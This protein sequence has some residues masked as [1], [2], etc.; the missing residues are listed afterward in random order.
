[1]PDR[2]TLPKQRI[3]IRQSKRDKRWRIEV[4]EMDGL[5]EF[6][7]KFVNSIEEHY[8]TSKKAVKVATRWFP[9]VAIEVVDPTGLT[10][11]EQD[12]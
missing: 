7:C 9:T 12:D 1:M 8:K 2:E 6:D 5:F 11:P 10:A 3:F 4:G